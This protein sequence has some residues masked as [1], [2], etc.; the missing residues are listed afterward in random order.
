MTQN[1]K[2]RIKQLERKL[3]HEKSSHSTSI[4]I[5]AFIVWLGV[6]FALAKDPTSWVVLIGGLAGAYFCFDVLPKI[7]N[8][9]N[10]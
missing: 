10:D 1:D 8:K 7:L 2:E 9:K 5:V 6:L 3:E 4:S